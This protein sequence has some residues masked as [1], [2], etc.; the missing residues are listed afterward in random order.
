MSRTA[1]TRSLAVSALMT[2]ASL[3]L[4]GA[5]MAG[6]PQGNNGT[7]KVAPYGEI[8]SIPNNQPHVGCTFELEWYGFD[9]N[10]VST[11][12]FEEQAP[13]TDVG[14]TVAGDTTAQLD[15]DDASGAG[16]P[17][18]FDGDEVYTLSFTGAP[19]PQQGYHVALTIQTPESNGSTVKH[20]VFWV[21][22][23][24]AP[25]TTPSPTPT[26]T[27]DETDTTGTSQTPASTPSTEES[28]ATAGT[29]GTTG[30]TGEDDNAA[31]NSDD[32]AG[33]VEVLGVQATADNG[34]KDQPKVNQNAG[35]EVLGQQARAAAP[36]PTAVN[37]GL[38]SDA[39]NDV[40]LPASLALLGVLL[41]LVAFAA[42]RRV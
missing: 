34:V 7:V 38:T 28:P 17:D 9:A 5:A 25:V 39:G 35:T 29:T 26:P 40:M 6:E 41:G 11:V 19:H 24:D 42:R 22:G 14:L 23:C 8:D 27:P 2:T 15:G 30:T 1:F 32:E 21:E 3:T 4:A 13:T 16:T 37:A 12:L 20:K 18:G 36:V 33:D 10:V 31:G